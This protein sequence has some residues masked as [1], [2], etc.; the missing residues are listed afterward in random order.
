MFISSDSYE[1]ANVVSAA[2]PRSGYSIPISRTARY[3]WKSFNSGVG[4]EARDCTAV[5]SIETLA[6]MID[7]A[8]G[9]VHRMRTRCQLVSYR[10]SAR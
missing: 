9:S 2:Q 5:L 6:R 10:R 4:R 8:E 1:K 3:R 7:T